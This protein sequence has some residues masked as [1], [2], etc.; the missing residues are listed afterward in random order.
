VATC[1]TT[2]ARVLRYR[3]PPA[4]QTLTL[5][6]RAAQRPRA[7]RLQPPNSFTD[8]QRSAD[9]RAACCHPKASLQG[10]AA[11]TAALSAAP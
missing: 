4:V 9:P 8:D 5:Q 2:L 3:V 7:H 11:T 1:T 6:R 10:S